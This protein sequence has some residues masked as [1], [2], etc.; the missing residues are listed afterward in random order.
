[1]YLKG[2]VPEGSG[3]SKVTNNLLILKLMVDKKLNILNT[4]MHCDFCCKKRK[5][6]GILCYEV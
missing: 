1:M 6:F 4:S 3:S 5:S 2:K